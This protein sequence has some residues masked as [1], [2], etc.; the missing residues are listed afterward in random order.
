ML[1]R[2]LGDE[3][4]AAGLTDYLSTYQYSNA[5]GAQFWDILSKV[6]CLHERYGHLLRGLLQHASTLEGLSLNEI[7][8]SWTLQAGHPYLTISTNRTTMVVRQHRFYYLRK[9]AEEDK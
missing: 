6:G 1:F 4:L 3:N 9:N 7:A 8:D 2:V 5:E